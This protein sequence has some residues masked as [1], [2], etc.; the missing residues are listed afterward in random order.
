MTLQAN[1]YKL[2]EKTFRFTL[3]IEFMKQFPSTVL[4]LTGLFVDY[5]GCENQLLNMPI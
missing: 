2:F 4:T 3:S 1:I 5:M